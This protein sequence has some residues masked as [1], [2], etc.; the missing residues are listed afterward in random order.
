MHICNP[1]NR[2][3][4]GVD[5]QCNRMLSAYPTRTVISQGAHHPSLEPGCRKCW[6]CSFGMR[7]RSWLPRD[8]GYYE[9]KTEAERQGGRG[10]K[11]PRA[12]LLYKMTRSWGA[13]KDAARR[14]ARALANKRVGQ[15]SRRA[16]GEGR[17]C[18][19]KSFVRYGGECRVREWRGWRW[20]ERVST[21]REAS[22]HRPW[23][24]LRRRP[25]SKLRER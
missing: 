21:L 13:N 6:Y 23:R 10:R 3:F 1:L 18:S 20:R 22:R 5:R 9:E 17:R 19:E 8:G 14:R 24:R 11:A 16:K 25:C 15:Q 2:C 7:M 4:R 12:G